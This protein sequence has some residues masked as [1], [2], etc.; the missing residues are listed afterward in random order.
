[1]SVTVL[2]KCCRRFNVERWPYRKFTSIDAMLNSKREVGGG[3]RAACLRA[4]AT[5]GGDQD[6]QVRQ[7]DVGAA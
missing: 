5:L 2:K 3:H 6:M 4:A 1:M 7:R